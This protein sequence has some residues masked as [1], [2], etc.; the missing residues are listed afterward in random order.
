MMIKNSK[1]LFYIFVF[2]SSILFSQSNQIKKVLNIKRSINKAP[3]I[4]G[5][6]NDDAWKGLEIANDFIMMAPNNGDKE[7]PNY[8]TEV[9]VLY[10]DEAIYIS[11][12]MYDPNSTPV[13]I[14]FSFSNICISLSSGT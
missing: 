14:F 13:I 12:M 11:A 8:K 5:L 6:L 7:N 1:L 2:T 9:K 3:K 10:N 4:D